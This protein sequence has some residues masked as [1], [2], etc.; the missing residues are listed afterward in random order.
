MYQ[1]TIDIEEAGSVRL[2]VHQMV[3]P[4]LVVERARFHGSMTLLKGKWESGLQV[5][6]TAGGDQSPACTAVSRPKKRHG[7]RA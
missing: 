5:S 4:D 2:F 7:N 1:M 6:G 3:V